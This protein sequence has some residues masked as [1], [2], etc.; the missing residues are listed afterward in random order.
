MIE[1]KG[2]Q[3]WSWKS[4]SSASYD[5]NAKLNVYRRSGVQ[6]YIVW[7]IYENQILWYQ[8]VEGQYEQLESNSEGIVESQIFPGLILPLE[9]M[10]SRDI[11]EVLAQLQTR[12]GSAAHKAYIQKL[13]VN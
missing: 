10:Q 4:A 1:L 7:Q 9:D 12:L 3:S 6:E 5:M 8:L 2:L 11:A 13:K